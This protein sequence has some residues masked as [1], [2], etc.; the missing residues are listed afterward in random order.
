L[1]CIPRESSPS[2][3][4]CTTQGA[5]QRRQRRVGFISKLDERSHSLVRRRTPLSYPDPSKRDSAPDR[6]AT[7]RRMTTVNVIDDVARRNYT[8]IVGSEWVSPL[9][10][11]HRV[12]CSHSTKD[13]LCCR[14]NSAPSDRG[15]V[16]R[17]SSDSKSTAAAGA[18][19]PAAIA[20]IIEALRKRFCGVALSLRSTRTGTTWPGRTSASGRAEGSARTASVR[21]RSRAEMPVEMPSAA[22]TAT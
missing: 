20:Q 10:Y 5:A 19:G 1:S 16:P 6:S 9:R 17:P 11:H 12:I 14:A 3:R 7:N 4:N 2:R 22:S 21:A 13:S 8:P 18:S 15:A